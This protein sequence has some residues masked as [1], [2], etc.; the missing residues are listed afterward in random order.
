MT[1]ATAPATVDDLCT[2]TQEP[3][4]FNDQ[5]GEMSTRAR[6]KVK[7]EMS[8]FVQKFI[9]AA[10]FV[11]MASADP[12]GNCDA[13]PKGGKPGFVKVLDSQRLLLPDV[14]G[15]RLF[16]SYQNMDANPHVGLLFMIPGVNDTVRVNGTVTIVNK[17]ELE[18]QKV[19]LELYWTDDNAKHLQ[20]I[21][22]N[23]EESYGH[24]PRAYNFAKLWDTDQIAENQANRPIP[25]RP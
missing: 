18:R 20:G 8:D 5:F 16:Q 22:I 6:V 12:D 7:G 23:V 1:T 9:A 2:V 21:I 24:C 15:N 10:P 17:E 13:S 11:V 19:E 25:L 3:S 4:R 14:A